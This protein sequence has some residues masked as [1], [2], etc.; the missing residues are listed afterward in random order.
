MALRSDWQGGGQTD[1]LMRVIGSDAL[2]VL[3]DNPKYVELLRGAVKRSNGRQTLETITTEIA[4]QRAALWFRKNSII[5]TET[6]RYPTGA[7]WLSVRTGVGHMSTLKSMM[8]EIEQYAEENEFDGLESVARIGWAR[9][10]KK[11]GYQET[12][13]FI[14]KAL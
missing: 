9:V 11:M 5:V 12:H 6:L 1:Q 3:I 10:G 2:D 4:Q 13:R 8:G 14:E 7:K